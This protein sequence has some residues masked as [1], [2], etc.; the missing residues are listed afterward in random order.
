MLS[1]TVLVTAVLSA[2]GADDVPAGGTEAPATGAGIQRPAPTTPAD[3]D[4]TI[5][6]DFGDVLTIVENADRGFADGRM[7][8][9]ERDGWH[10]LA[11]RVLGR[12]PSGGDSAVQTAIGALQAAAPAGAPGA[13]AESTGVRSPEWSRAEADLATACE[14]VGAPLAIDVFTGG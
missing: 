13:F 2:C 6:T 10:R 4:A 3:D 12:L 5:C 7:A 14:E 1:A 9:Q 11:D 8:E